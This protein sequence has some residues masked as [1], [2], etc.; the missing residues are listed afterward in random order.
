ML[1]PGR[2]E[3]DSIKRFMK[4]KIEYTDEPMEAK[5][6]E[7]FLPSPDELAMKDDNVRVT[8]TLS[9][10]SVKFFRDVPQ[11]PKVLISAWRGKC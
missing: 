1:A 10:E 3:C 11:R 8:I 5:V 4:K 6:I 2:R 9:R 7:D